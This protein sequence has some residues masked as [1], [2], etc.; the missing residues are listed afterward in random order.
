MFGRSRGGFTTKL[1]S[2]CDL[3]GRPLGFVL[4]PG[5]THDT[6]GFIPLFRMIED[7]I[8]AFGALLSWAREHLDAPLTVETLGQRRGRQRIQPSRE[9]LPR[10]RS[11][12]YARA[13]LGTPVRCRAFPSRCL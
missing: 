2:R 3:K 1:Y 5:Q 7:K 10:A 13:L 11:V 12:T 4:T 9:H 6:Q 8:D